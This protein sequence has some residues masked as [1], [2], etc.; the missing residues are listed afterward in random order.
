[1]FILYLISTLPDLEGLSTAQGYWASGV[2][3]K[4]TDDIDAS[5][6]ANWNVGDHDNDNDGTTPE[7]PMGFSPIGNASVGFAATFDGVI[8]IPCT[9]LEVSVKIITVQFLSINKSNT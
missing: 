3:L 1:M 8:N 7:V 5:D 4:L 6:T 9:W 2:H